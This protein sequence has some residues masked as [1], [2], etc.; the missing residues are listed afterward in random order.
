MEVF[1]ERIILF[2]IT[3]PETNVDRIITFNPNG[4]LFEFWHRFEKNGIPLRT[5]GVY[6]PNEIYE[7]VGCFK[8]THSSKT[9]LSEKDL[10]KLIGAL[11]DFG[12]YC[13]WEDEQKLNV[14]VKPLKEIEEEFK[15]SMALSAA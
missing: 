15:N 9:F 2:S 12:E 13:A 10:G 3:D 11:K 14:A 4:E 6:S 7:I 5:S 1:M 8:M